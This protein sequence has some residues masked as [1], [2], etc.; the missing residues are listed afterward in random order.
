[1]DQRAIRTWSRPNNFNTVNVRH[2]PTSMAY[3]DTNTW[4]VAITS[5]FMSLSL[6]KSSALYLCKEHTI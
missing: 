2:S 3:F 5:I 1:M 4:P 6:P